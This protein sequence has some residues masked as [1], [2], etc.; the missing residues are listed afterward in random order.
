MPIPQPPYAWPQ[1]PEEEKTAAEIAHI[2]TASFNQSGT[3]I[4]DP[5]AILSAAR[6]IAQSDRLKV[7]FKLG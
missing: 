6:H 1:G 4:K 3:K 2:L 7:T 5:E